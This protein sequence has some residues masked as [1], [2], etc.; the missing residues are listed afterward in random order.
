MEHN[1][2]ELPDSVEMLDSMTSDELRL[3]Y[4]QV[5]GTRPPSRASRVFLTG[6]IAWTQ[7]A[8]AHNQAPTTLRG[9]LI[10]RST[11]SRQK[12]VHHYKPGTRLVRE[13]HGVTYEVVVTDDG[14]LWQDRAYRSLTAIAREITGA[15]WSGP[16]FFGLLNKKK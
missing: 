7:Q 6:N 14:Y 2:P 5:L 1:Y 11:P 10:K 9:E 13:W 12:K 3:L 8:Q 15:N 16:R 4:Q